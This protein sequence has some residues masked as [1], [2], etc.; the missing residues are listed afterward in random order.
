MLPGVEGRSIYYVRW[1]GSFQQI[2][3]SSFQQ[4]RAAFVSPIAQSACHHARMADR[5]DSDRE[6][7]KSLPHSR[8]VRRSAKRS[9]RPTAA[10]TT[11]APSPKPA[12]TQKTPPTS[13][14]K[15]S[16]GKAR[17]V[18]AGKKTPLKPASTAAP[19]AA[20]GTPKAAAGDRGNAARSRAA[21]QGAR[22]DA[23]P[24]ERVAPAR[25]VPPAGYATPAAEGERE[26]DSDAAK[27]LSTTVQAVNEL[28]QIGLTVGRQALQSMLDRLP[29]P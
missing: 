15:S 28:T 27:L 2:A 22:R 24:R 1:H 25:K 7:L 6:V 13:R 4:L 21:A 26:R 19:K 12:A 18:T 16:A 29:K 9:S 20:S 17:A 11:A 3:Q 5:Q 10:A 8:P 23:A 14:R